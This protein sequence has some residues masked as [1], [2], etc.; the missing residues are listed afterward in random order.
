MVTFAE[1]WQTFLARLFELAKGRVGSYVR[2]EAVVAPLDFDQDTTL[3]IV[4][5]LLAKGFIVAD[6]RDPV[7]ITAI[8]I[9]TLQAAELI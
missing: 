4:E 5:Y 8:G 7:A 6:R 1:K 3:S 9:D 2:V